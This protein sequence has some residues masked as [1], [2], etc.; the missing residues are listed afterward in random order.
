MPSDV[1]QNLPELT[2]SNLTVF[3]CHS[4]KDIDK[5]NEICDCLSRN[6]ISY[7]IA[8]RDPK[9]GDIFTENIA[10]A[11][12]TS[13]A[14]L[15]VCSANSN[16]SRMVLSEIAYAF[17]KNMTI[18]PYVIE[19]AQMAKA[20]KLYLAPV[21]RI[22]ATTNVYGP[23]IDRLISTI[24]ILENQHKTGTQMAIPKGSTPIPTLLPKSSVIGR[25]IAD[26]RDIGFVGAY[27]SLVDSNKNQ[28]YYEMI[29][30]GR[31]NFRF[32]DID[33]SDTTKF[34]RVYANLTPFGESYSDI[35]KLEAGKATIANVNIITG[36]AKIT[37]TTENSDFNMDGTHNVD[38]SGF[39]LITAYVYDALGYKVHDGCYIMFNLIN[40]S[41][42]NGKLVSLTSKITN[43]NMAGAFTKGGC[44]QV[45]F[46]GATKN[47][48]CKIEAYCIYDYSIRST[49]QL[50]VKVH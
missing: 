8:P 1:S 29:S 27:V 18:I 12:D 46:G 45:K 23:P 49:I 15:F 2:D 44:A 41:I 7:W 35:L 5:V 28:I 30:E 4:E 38:G 20:L 19:E 47:G 14:L 16:D 42:D 26:N 48:L 6:G 31:G 10:N 9:G 34:Y 25:V 37:V 50:N 39:I 33:I 24:K 40:S 36:P 43:N 32:D 21:H 17:E 22:D 13:L 3:I 11:I